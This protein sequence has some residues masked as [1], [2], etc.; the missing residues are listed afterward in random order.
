[1]RERRQR[2]L[3]A[4]VSLF[5]EKGFLGAT[6]DEIAARAGVTKRTLYRHM[7]SKHSLL[8][9]IHQNFLDVGRARWDE[10]VSRGGTATERFTNLVRAHVMT[11]S[12]H[13]Q[14]IQVFFEE[15]KHLTPEDRDRIVSQRDEY[16]AIMRDVI[17]EGMESGDF[18][19]G[20]ADVLSL[21]VLGTISDIYR[22]Y[23]PDGELSPE[24][25]SQFIV[26]SLLEGLAA[27]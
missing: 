20:D 25:A 2:I 27:P 17:R 23:R 3:D 26:D 10:V 22:W 6:S 4:A 12:E 14:A 7:E 5:H 9:E 11:V 24:P 15:M 13:R 8:R 19:S 18:R 16:Q 1:M 21:L